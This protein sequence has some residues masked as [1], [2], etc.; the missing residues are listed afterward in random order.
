M[1]SS[2]SL[3]ALALASASGLAQ[4][5]APPELAG[6]SGPS[7][8]AGNGA[9]RFDQVGYATRNGGT[10]GVTAAHPTLPLGSIA[11]VT[12]LDTG[13]T[14][15]V[16]IAAGGPAD[17]RTVIAL[18]SAAADLLG[19]GTRAAVR[20]RAVAASAPDAA[21]LARGEAAAPRID[22]PPALLAALRRQLPT[23]P[24]APRP[25]S[26]RKAPVPGAPYARP[27]APVTKP[28]PF[29]KSAPATRPTSV[30]PS[31]GGLVVQ[32]AAF[33][34]QARARAIAGSLGGS[35]QP[36]G[37]LWRVRLGPFRDRTAAQRARDD[38]ARRGYAGAQIIPAS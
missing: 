5:E 12:A 36:V 9:E 22:A 25:A 18:S 32:V 7:A 19:V 28:A 37:A 14:I 17:A 34:D 1:R 2:A 35:V 31:P 30:Q 11:E 23:A 4:G 10:A 29:A 20:V 3:L 38:A 24:A 13:R 8:T 33:A 21:A 15:L 26:A 6:S 27:A 16:R